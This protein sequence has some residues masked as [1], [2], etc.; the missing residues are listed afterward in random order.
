MQLISLLIPF[1]FF[2]ASFCDVAYIVPIDPLSCTPNKDSNTCLL[3]YQTNSGYVA[4]VNVAKKWITAY[5]YSPS[6][7]V[8][9]QKTVDIPGVATFYNWGL[10]KKY[11]LLL[12]SEKL[13]GMNYNTPKFYYDG[14]TYTFKDCSCR[15][16]GSGNFVCACPF[17]CS[18]FPIE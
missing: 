7:Q 15:G 1:G 5:V 6:C 14:V 8:W 13:D 3:N 16:V 9:G 11:P 12:S 2:A 10:S 4:G 18:P 17:H